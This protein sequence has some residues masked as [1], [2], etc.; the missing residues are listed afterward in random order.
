M[1]WR[2]GEPCADGQ[3]KADA[4]TRRA[5]GAFG[6]CEELAQNECPGNPGTAEP[7]IGGCLQAMWD[8]GP[9]GGHHDIMASTKYTQVA[10][11]MHDT[12]NGTFWS[13]QNFR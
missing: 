6:R 2:E 8:E 1:R 13:V 10:C 5:H 7:N 3:A 12:G 4:A 11:G 9:G